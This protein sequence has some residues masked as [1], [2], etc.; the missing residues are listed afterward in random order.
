MEGRSVA[1]VHHVEQRVGP[2]GLTMPASSVHL[3]IVRLV[4]AAV[5][6]ELDFDVD[7]LEDLRVAVDELC[8]SLMEHAPPGARVHLTLCSGPGRHLV[9]EGSL[10]VDAGPLNI[11]PVSESLLDGL[12]LEWST[13]MTSSFRLVAPRVARSGLGR[14]PGLDGSSL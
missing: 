4:T 9:A 5:A 2:V 13:G 8:G 12:D 10:S 14:P 7:Q 6:V 1:E 11:D 3:R